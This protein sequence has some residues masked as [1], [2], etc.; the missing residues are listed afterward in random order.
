MFCSHKFSQWNGHTYS[1]A[2]IFHTWTNHHWPAEEVYLAVTR[3]GGEEWRE[4]GQLDLVQTRLSLEFGS[5]ILETCK[6]VN[7]NV[8]PLLEYV[9]K[10]YH[11]LSFSISEVICQNCNAEKWN[12]Q[13]SYLPWYVRKY[14]S[15]CMWQLHPCR[16]KSLMNT[17]V[18]FLLDVSEFCLTFLLS[19]LCVH[20]QVALRLCIL[21]PSFAYL[22]N[23]CLFVC[24]FM[25][26]NI[27][28]WSQ[29]KNLSS[30]LIDV[31]S[32]ISDADWQMMIN[33]AVVRDIV[34]KGR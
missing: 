23:L 6:C 27:S 2:M 13:L 28:V 21:Y 4:S 9:C 24:M 20:L 30:I 29:Q 10:L 22:N 31:K 1:T 5:R 32:E 3:D 19:V 15:M 26:T 25:E 33:L 16:I 8:P 7:L 14:G 11:R 18:N 12:V 34:E 17:G